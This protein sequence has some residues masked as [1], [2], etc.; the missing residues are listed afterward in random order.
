MTIEKMIFL[1][2]AGMSVATKQVETSSFVCLKL[3]T[4]ASVAT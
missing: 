3:Q 2:Q 1:L 4:R